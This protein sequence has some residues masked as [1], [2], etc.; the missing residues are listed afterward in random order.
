MDKTKNK[1]VIRLRL[2]KI[3]SERNMTQTK[4]AELSGLSRNTI[5]S[6]VHQPAQIR[7]NTLD[8]LCD[9][10]GVPVHELIEQ[11]PTE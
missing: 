4:L 7:F 3:L 5:S 6:L 2:D 9:T 8:I 10:L 11:V 1:L